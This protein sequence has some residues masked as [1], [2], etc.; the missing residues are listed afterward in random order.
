MEPIDFTFQISFPGCHSFPATWH[1]VYQNL[2]EKKKTLR[3]N[4]FWG[5]QLL[6]NLENFRFLA[7]S[8]VGFTCRQFYCRG[9]IGWDIRKSGWIVPT[10]TV[11]L[12]GNRLSLHLEIICIVVSPFK[13]K[14]FQRWG[15][16]VHEKNWFDLGNSPTVITRLEDY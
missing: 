10:A 15:I 13:Q 12:Y 9:G 11:C 5:F 3:S 14:S 7:P 2:N 4:F 1:T 16:Q 8:H 6:C